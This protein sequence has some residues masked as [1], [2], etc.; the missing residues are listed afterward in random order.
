MDERSSLGTASK[1]GC[2]SR[3]AHVEATSN[4]SRAAQV[5]AA[6]RHVHGAGLA[7]RDVKPDNVLLDGPRAVLVDL[8][9][10]ARI[11]D[12]VGDRRG[13][14]ALA[15]EAAEHSTAPYRA[16]EL[17]AP[18]PG[19]AVDGKC[20]VWALGCVAWALCYGYGPSEAEPRDDGS[21]A[22]VDAG[23]SRSLSAPKG[24]PQAPQRRHAPAFA[25]ALEDLARALLAPDP[26]AR[27]D[28]AAAAALVDGL[29][30]SLD[31]RAAGERV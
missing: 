16:P 5:A 13:A 29:A 26:A 22:F 20:D 31:G 28:A 24:A 18:Q 17:W 2:V 8:G 23:H 27:P 1:R 4:L 7:H 21:F 11:P 25:A 15:D 14:L 9:S 10:C 6:L 3:N 12:V 30:A 19:D